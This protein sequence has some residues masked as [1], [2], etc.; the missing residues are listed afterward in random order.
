VRS[1]YKNYLTRIDHIT[2]LYSVISFNEQVISFDPDYLDDSLEIPLSTNF[3][4]WTTIKNKRDILSSI[5]SGQ[6]HQ[7]NCYQAVVSLVSNFENLIEQL[8]KH[9]SITKSE[10][11]IALPDNLREGID[12]PI[13]KKIHAI[14]S[15]LSIDSNVIGNHESAY[16]CKIIKVRNCI[17]HRL[18]VP[19][20][21]ELKLLQNWITDGSITFDRDHIDDFVHF[22]LMPVKSMILEID[23]KLSENVVLLNSY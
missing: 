1:L 13:I 18:G 12:A 14:H 7:I 21:S 23:Q 16:Y 6:L 19:N 15:K 5:K 4:S 2:T 8:A 11:N 20:N 17:V 22:F 9:F 10:I 3:G